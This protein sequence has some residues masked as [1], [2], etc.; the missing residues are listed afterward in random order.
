MLVTIMVLGFCA[1]LCNQTP[2]YPYD[3]LRSIECTSCPALPIM[4]KCRLSPVGLN[5]GHTQLA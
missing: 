3:K 5:G 1:S 4:P 2:L